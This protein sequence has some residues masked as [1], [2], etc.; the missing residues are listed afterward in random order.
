MAFSFVTQS[1]IQGVQMLPVRLTI[2]PAILALCLIAN[3]P[4][5]ATILVPEDQPTIRACVNAAAPG[6]TCSVAP[7]VYFEF[8]PDSN[9]VSGVIANV[10]VNKA[11]GLRSRELY[12]AVLDGRM[13][14]TTAFLVIQANATVEGFVIQNVNTGV[15]SRGSPGG[16]GFSWSARNLIIRNASAFGIGVD[17][18]GP[19][20][21]PANYSSA[22]LSNIVV[23]SADVAYYTNDA[24]S[25]D[26]RNSIASNSRVGFQGCDDVFLTFSYSMTSAVQ[27][28]REAA[29]SPSDLPIAGPGFFDANADFGHVR[30]ALHDFPFFLRC[31][32]PAIDAGDPGA[33]FDDTLFPPSWGA[34]TNDIGA[35]GGPGATAS[36]SALERQQLVGQLLRVDRSGGDSVVSWCHLPDFTESDLIRGDLGA[37][38]SSGG[39]FSVATSECLANDVSTTSFTSSGV[40]SLGDAFWFLTRCD[41]CPGKGSYDSG[42]S[43]Q[44]GVR[45][46]GIA[47]S[48][49]DCP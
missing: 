21:A 28:V 49:N 9:P 17:E 39:N 41:N 32:S 45:D 15:I 34:A 1:Q 31:S 11:I 47:A 5:A 2:V 23:D 22:A 3:S 46:P 48:G 37:L 26:V 44:V 14:P 13:D 12:Q 6:D 7:G 33:Q 43:S 29:C 19:D 27:K 30:T 40:P 20:P 18:W 35:Y 24:G 25:L 8:P 10:I 16:V 42:A 4:Y 38:R 36:L